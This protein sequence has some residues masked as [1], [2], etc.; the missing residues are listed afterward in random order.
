MNIKVFKKLIK[1][2]VID[3][4]HEELPYILEEHMAKQEKKALRE[5]RTAGFTSADVM[6]G[7]PSPGGIRSQLAAQMGEAFGLHPQPQQ[8]LK[9]I[10]AVDDVTGGK[11]NPFAAFIADAAASMTPQEKAGLKNLG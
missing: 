6:T 7:N 9:I 4:I 5:G 11:V 8:Q 3:A 10:D 1:E 2:A